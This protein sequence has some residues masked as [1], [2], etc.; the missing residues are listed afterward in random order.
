VRNDSIYLDPQT[1]DGGPAT[2]P[3]DEVLHPE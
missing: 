1:N 2:A 3:V